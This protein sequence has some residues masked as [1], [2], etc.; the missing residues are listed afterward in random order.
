MDP[1]DAGHLLLSAARTASIASRSPKDRRDER[2]HEPR[3][4]KRRMRASDGAQRFTVGA[5][6]KARRRAVTWCRGI[7][8]R[9]SRRPGRVAPPTSRA[10]RLRA[11]PQRCDRPRRSRRGPRRGP[12]PGARGRLTRRD[13][14]WQRRHQCVSV[15]FDRCGGWSGSWPRAIPRRW[16]GDRRP[17]RQQGPHGW[18]GGDGRQ[19]DGARR[20]HARACDRHAARHESFASASRPARAA[21][22][23][24]HTS[25]GNARPEQGL[26]PMRTWRR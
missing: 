17:A 14:P 25:A 22:V 8:V 20:A 13:A 12:R 11:R 23:L 26:R 16:P 2:G 6:L 21:S 10:R 7:P 3:G 24:R 15:T 5:S 4:P 1:D 9:A 18:V 19:F